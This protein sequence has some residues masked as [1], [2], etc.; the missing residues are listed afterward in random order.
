MLT[1]N[2]SSFGPSFG[3]EISSNSFGDE[4]S[5][6]MSLTLFGNNSDSQNKVMGLLSNTTYLLDTLLSEDVY[7]KRIRPGFGGNPSF[8]LFSLHIKFVEDILP[9][10]LNTKTLKHF[11]NTER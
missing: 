5:S 11:P 4:I 2:G 3:D 8:I 7:D 6:N 9:C 10:I 1:K